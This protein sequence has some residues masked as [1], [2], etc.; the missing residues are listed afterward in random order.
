[1][2]QDLDT[3]RKT[4]VD[5]KTRNNTNAQNL[6]VMRA[7]ITELEN[8]KKEMENSNSELQKKLR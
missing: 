2:E 3:E 1:M 7:K 4:S 6:K 5:F 8:E